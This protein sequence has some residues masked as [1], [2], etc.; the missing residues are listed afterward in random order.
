MVERGQMR[1][2]AIPEHRIAHRRAF[3][4]LRSA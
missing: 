1:I 2:V 4:D 3:R